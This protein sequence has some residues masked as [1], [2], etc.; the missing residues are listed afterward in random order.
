M[1]TDTCFDVPV[2]ALQSDLANLDEAESRIQHFFEKKK[3][4]FWSDFEPHVTF[5]VFGVRKSSG[6]LGLFTLRD[7][8]ISGK[9]PTFR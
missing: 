5:L 8:F 9:I 3:S 6:Y 2:I 4:E 7:L 1:A